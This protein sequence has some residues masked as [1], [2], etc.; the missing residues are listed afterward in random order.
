MNEIEER[1]LPIGTVVMLSGGTK[2]C[3]ITGFCS[4]EETD[5]KIW[6][7][8][9]CMFPEGILSSNETCLFDHSQ[10]EKIYHMGLADDEEEK[11]FK[12]DLNE[13]LKKQGETQ[14]IKTPKT[15][16]NSDDNNN[17]LF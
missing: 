12:T 17:N 1:Y 11:Q 3:M 2:R 7:Y 4:A 8:S 13:Y 9:G 10:I 16:S 14:E 5:K 15:T 6:D